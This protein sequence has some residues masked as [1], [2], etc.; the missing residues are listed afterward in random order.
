MP[1]AGQ[2][3][4]AAGAAAALIPGVGTAVGAGLGLL[5]TG[6]D[7]YSQ[8]KESGDLLGQYRE[9]K[10]ILQS[11]ITA[12]G[13]EREAELGIFTEGTERQREQ[14]G[15]MAGAESEA[16]TEQYGKASV[17]SGLVRSSVDALAKETKEKQQKQ[18]GYQFEG[19]RAGELAGQRDI[20]K[21]FT[22][23]EDVLLGQLGE[24]EGAMSAQKRQRKGLLVGGLAMFGALGVAKGY[25]MTKK[26]T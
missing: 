14:A 12:L 25:A 22:E 9:E 7:M 8:Y 6:L 4:Q 20:E 23:R 11:D 16:S 26:D 5:G 17:K 3:L 19:M 10:S 21:S 18:A 1:S 2:G 15:F 24:I 13:E